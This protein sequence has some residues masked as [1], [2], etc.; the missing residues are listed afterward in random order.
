MRRLVETEL[1]TD[2]GTKVKYVGRFLGF[3]HD[4]DYKKILGNPAIT[5]RIESKPTKDL[6]KSCNKANESNWGLNGVRF[7]LVLRKRDEKA[8]LNK[9]LLVSEKLNYVSEL[10]PEIKEVIFAATSGNQIIMRE[11]EAKSE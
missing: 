1:K 10:R 2:T 9:V 11:S 7:V 5:S 8:V 6:I 4:E 3:I